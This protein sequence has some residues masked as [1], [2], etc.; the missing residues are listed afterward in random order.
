MK[1]SRSFLN[2]LVVCWKKSFFTFQIRWFSL[3][4]VVFQSVSTENA[5]SAQM[6]V[7]I[8][9]ICS[10]FLEYF[11]VWIKK[12]KWFLT[13][14]S[15][16]YAIWLIFECTTAKMARKSWDLLHNS[17]WVSLVS[18]MA[19]LRGWSADGSILVQ[20]FLNWSLQKGLNFITYFYYIC[21][22]GQ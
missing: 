8:C 10:L 14:S 12:A 21:I 22:L 2:R 4:V 5:Y 15:K 16:Y 11:K 20:T 13:L 9:T 19:H 7:S 17:C 1:L 18:H 3:F 6:N